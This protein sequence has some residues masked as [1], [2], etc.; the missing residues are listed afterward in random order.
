MRIG[1]FTAL[2]GNLNFEQALDTAAAAGVGL[3][4]A[5]PQR[6][7]LAALALYLAMGWAGVLAGG[8]FFATLSVPVI[9][10][11]VTGGLLYTAG[12]AF[13]LWDRLPFHYT[14]WHV[15]V[16]TASLT[17]YAAVTLHVVETA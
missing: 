11:I 12:V 10:L 5:A 7:R 8:S 1:V 6:F 13:Y 17:F 4:I 2:W 15:F 3:K 9:V 14:I 16:L